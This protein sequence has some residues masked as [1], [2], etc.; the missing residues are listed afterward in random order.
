MARRAG[1]DYN[2]FMP[3]RAKQFVYGLFYFIILGGLA[4][5]IYFLFLKPA[6]SCFDN[7]QNEGELGID[8]GGP[9]AT[10]CIP[11]TIQQVLPLG[12]VHVFT[13]VKGHAA[14]LV[15]LENANADFAAESFNYE[16]TIRGADGSSTVATVNGTSFAYADETKYLVVPNESVSGT[17]STADIAI[18]NIQWLDAAQMGLVPQFA[19]ANI[20]SVAGTDGYATVSGNITDRDASSF[21]NILVVAVFKN[22]AGAPIGASQTELDSISPG[23]TQNFSVSYPLLPNENI[24]ATELKAYAERK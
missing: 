8:C 21:S 9:C 2:D 3:R 19:F 24:S 22:A 17:P 4:T 16:I 15:Q 20:T 6:P 10:S 14:V 18:S 12:A 11:S 1:K 13:P 7:V 23:A 5:G